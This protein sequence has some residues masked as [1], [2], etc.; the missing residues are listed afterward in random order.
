MA[1][2]CGFSLYSQIKNSSGHI[3]MSLFIHILM[4]CLFGYF[5]SFCV[6]LCASICIY[7]CVG[8]SIVC[9]CQCMQRPEDNFNFHSLGAA[10]LVS[11]G[12]SYLVLICI[13]QMV[14]DW[15]FFFNGLSAVWV[16][17]V[18]SVPLSIFLLDCFL[19]LNFRSVFISSNV[20]ILQMLP[21]IWA[22][23]SFPPQCLS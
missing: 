9:V 3:F 1:L 10:H 2:H 5:Y 22:V 14:Q 4:T 15:A 17:G 7:L 19:S 20:R 16:L 6:C 13:F 23:L 12:A 11:K 18:C 8:V 21:P